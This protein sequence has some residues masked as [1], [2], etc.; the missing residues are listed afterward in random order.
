MGQSIPWLTGDGEMAELIRSKDWS[1]T[2][3]GP[4][5][6]WPQTLQTTLGIVLRN[7]FPMMIWWGPELLNFY[8][9]AYR[10]ILR[11]KHPNSLGASAPKLWAEVWDFAGPLAR[12][13]MDGGPATWMED[14]QLF[15]K[16]GDMIEE[17]YFTFSLSPIQGDDGKVAGILN[18]VQESTVKVQ[19][20]RLLTMLHDLAARTSTA[21]SEGEAYRVIMNVLSEFELDIPFA[22][23]YKYDDKKE[24]FQLSG[25]V[26]FG[27]YDGP[28]KNPDSWPLQDALDA[29]DEVIIDNIDQKFP[30][31]PKTQWGESPKQAI[32]LPV[33][34][35]EAGVE[36][37]L[38][39]GISP[40]RKLDVKYSLLFVAL[41]EQLANV[42]VN[43]RTIEI[44]KRRIKELASLDQ[45]KTVFFSNIS[46][47]FRTPLTLMLG[48]L[49]EALFRKDLP[50][51]HQEQLHLM[52]RNTLRLKRLVNSLLEFSR[53]EAGKFKGVFEPI[54]LGTYTTELASAFE[55]AFQDAGLNFE[56]DCKPMKRDVYIDYEKWETIILNLLSNALKYTFIG[57]I[58][59]TLEEKADYAELVI[60]DTGIG[61][62]KDE[63]PHLFERFH[64]VD[65][66]KTRTAEGTGIGLAVV[67]E[68]IKLHGGSIKVQSKVEKGTTFT[69]RIPFGSAH[70]PKDQVV[71][72]L[73]GGRDASTQTRAY[74]EEAMG[75]IKHTNMKQ[76]DP[77]HTKSR[78]DETILVVDDNADMR[79]YISRILDANTSLT[80][81]AVSNGLEALEAIKEKVPS[82]VITD[83]MMPKMDGIE[84]VGRLRKD[85]KVG[86]IPIIFLSARAGDREKAAGIVEGVDAYLTKPFS[87]YE[88]VATV[89]TQLDLTSLRQRK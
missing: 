25:S 3:I 14:T 10:P 50:P 47:E 70:L 5:E 83:I 39:A 58:K 46:H 78:G 84:L 82:L 81:K 87:I 20:E 59:L 32:V 1:K 63:L 72:K 79:S 44:E 31:L 29:N 71:S 43:A 77:A 16:S 35:S 22:L 11:D 57:G 73:H 12:S 80:I 6:K 62:P 4:I 61:I 36:S 13:V 28:A 66:A 55:S 74:I 27:Q 7:R 2:S 23:L 53:I 33:V 67:N 30:S 88:L 17:T 19:S 21:K 26:G 56:I 52:F 15:I 68:L 65:G 85:P 69:V 54:E 48:P 40:H 8:N 9:D 76:I 18:T 51:D 86:K 42:M 37:V 89:R 24:A 45:A 75:W 60:E 49:E 38:V 64:R 41:A 34:R